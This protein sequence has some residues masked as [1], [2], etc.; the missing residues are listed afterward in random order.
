[1]TKAFGACTAVAELGVGHLQLGALAADDGPV[2][3]PVELERFTGT[4]G[5]G[6]EGASASGSLGFLPF[7]LP[8]TCKGGHAVVRT[9]VAQSGQVGVHLLDR[10]PLFARFAGLSLEPA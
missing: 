6:H 3:A 10:A 1:M 5:Q 8:D 4:E 7:G 2:F 9:V